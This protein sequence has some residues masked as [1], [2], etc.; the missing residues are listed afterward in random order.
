MGARRFGSYFLIGCC[1][2]PTV[3][4]RPE[5]ALEETL[6][7][8]IR[9]AERAA[10]ARADRPIIILREDATAALILSCT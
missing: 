3:E 2:E 1:V 4:G 5:A 8:P 7:A 9:G 6:R 10:S